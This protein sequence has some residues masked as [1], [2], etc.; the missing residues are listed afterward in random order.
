VGWTSFG[1]MRTYSDL[2]DI[3][4]LTPEEQTQNGIKTFHIVPYLPLNISEE[5]YPYW[6]ESELTR[7]GVLVR[8]TLKAAH[9]VDTPRPSGFTLTG[10]S[11]NTSAQL[12]VPVVFTLNS[13]GGA[14]PVLYS[15]YILKNGRVYYS[16]AYSLQNSFEYTFTAGGEYT[17]RAYAQ[18]GSAMRLLYTQNITV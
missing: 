17:L 13:Q 18:N 4:M 6:K 7:Q 14:Q 8:S 9:P 15:L 5:G 3:S 10:I 11:T 12:N 16:R 1:F 2:C